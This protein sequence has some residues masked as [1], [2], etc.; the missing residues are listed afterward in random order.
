MAWRSSIEMTW[1]TRIRGGVFAL[2]LLAC[3]AVAA[4]PARADTT[5]ADPSAASA[6]E[7]RIAHGLELR[8]ARRDAEALAEF[9]LAYWL[10]PS[11]RALGQMAL[12]EA[13]VG[14]WVEAEQ[15]LEDVIARH[16]DPWVEKVRADLGDSLRDVRT[17]LAELELAVTPEGAEVRINGVPAKPDRATGTYHVVSGRVLV[18][19]DA[20]G[21]APARRVFETPPGVRTRDSFALAPEKSPSAPPDSPTSPPT[22]GPPSRVTALSPPPRPER[23]LPRV[24]LF[25]SIATA[26]AAVGVGTAAAIERQRAVQTYNDDSRCEYGG[27]PRSVRCGGVAVDVNRFTSEM[28]AR[29][30]TASVA[31]IAGL[32]FALVA[33]RALRIEVAPVG[34][35]GGLL[36]L[37]KDF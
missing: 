28:T 22:N 12:A 33:P 9:R 16:G 13:A 3:L 11:P 35:D 27:I 8:R 29:Y 18:E 26:G 25:S 17:H 36:R 4:S 31:A 15:T 5:P 2:P 24:L 21:F 1:R 37:A 10:D 30:L 34:H 6:A 19:V 14:L 7:A 23:D 32:V 20:A